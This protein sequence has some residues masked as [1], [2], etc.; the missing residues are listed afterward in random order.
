MTEKQMLK[1]EGKKAILIKWNQLKN[2]SKLEVF[3]N[4]KE[5]N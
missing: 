4:E 2:I 3:E 5:S 1:L